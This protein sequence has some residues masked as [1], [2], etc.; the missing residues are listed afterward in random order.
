SDCVP[1][2]DRSWSRA[3]LPD[4]PR[5]PAQVPEDASTPRDGPHLPSF[6]GPPLAG[7]ER[8]WWIAGGSL[9]ASVVR[10]LRP[11]LLPG[12]QHP[13][14]LAPRAAAP[15]GGARHAR[16]GGAGARG[17]PGR[18][19]PPV[20]LGRRVEEGP[21]LRLGRQGGGEIGGEVVPLRSLRGQDHLDP[22]AR[23]DAAV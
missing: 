17:A 20:D 22:V 11:F 18:G 10:G 23:G 1:V 21:R 4:P 12:L 5:V 16:G 14:P 9:E 15:L 13:V 6:S 2:P 19:A 8:R 3:S 7:S